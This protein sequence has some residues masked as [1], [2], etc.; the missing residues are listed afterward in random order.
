LATRGLEEGHRVFADVLL[1]LVSLFIMLL[2][3]ILFTN[4]IELLGHRLKMHQ[5]AVGSILAAIG[6]ALPETLIPIVAILIFRDP[7]A[8]EVGVGAIAGAPFMLATLGLFVTGAGVILFSAL[9]QRTLQLRVEPDSVARDLAFFVLLYGLAVATAFIR[10]HALHV[11]IALAMLGS[12][13]IYLRRTLDAESEALELPD[14]L[15]LTRLFKVPHRTAWVLTQVAA[16]V[17]LMLIGAH[18]FIGAV[19]GIANRLAVAALLVS[20]ILTPVATELPEKLNSI[21]WVRRNKDALALGNM[22]GAMV[23]QSCFP[24]V[25]GMIFTPWDL[26]GATFISALIALAMALFILGWV[27]LRRSLSPWP[28]LAGGLMYGLFILC[29]LRR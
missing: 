27:K 18:V 8:R 28:L 9:G 5:S 1:W 19:E 14:L 10:I 26:P 17:A 4:G 23:F 25:F 2:A 16:S 6:T 13:G 24:V 15:L 7:S 20:I 29:A 21:L 22:T 11:A 12:Y 3:C